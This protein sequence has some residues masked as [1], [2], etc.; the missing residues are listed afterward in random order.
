MKKYFHRHTRIIFDQI[1][2]HPMAQYIELTVT[3]IHMYQYQL[4]HIWVSLKSKDDSSLPRWPLHRIPYY[5]ITGF[6]QSE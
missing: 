3:S 5:L 1:S 4:M 2:E 6:H